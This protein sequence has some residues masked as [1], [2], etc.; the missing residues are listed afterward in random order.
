MKRMKFLKMK[1]KMKMKVVFLNSLRN[2]TK[3]SVYLRKL[4]ELVRNNYR[5]IDTKIIEAR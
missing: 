2:E 5:R 1:M 3:E 4:R